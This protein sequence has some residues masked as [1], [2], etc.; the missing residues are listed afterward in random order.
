MTGAPGSYPRSV[1]AAQH[2]IHSNFQSGTKK[3]KPLF[4]CVDQNSLQRKPAAIADSESVKRPRGAT[5]S[6]EFQGE[7]A[8]FR[9]SEAW[10]RTLDNM[11][12]RGTHVPPV[13]GSGAGE[14]GFREGRLEK[15]R[16]A[17]CVCV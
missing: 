2:H 5:G 1:G 11:Q 9:F 16:T 3:K 13:T 12:A 10:G 7:T 15:T 4:L 17:V 14:G 8:A 6:L